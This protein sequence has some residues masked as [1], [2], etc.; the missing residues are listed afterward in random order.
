MCDVVAAHLGSEVC[1]RLFDVLR[2][3][4]AEKDLSLRRPKDK[5]SIIDIFPC[6]RVVFLRGRGLVSVDLPCRI[7]KVNNRAVIHK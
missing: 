5:A 1:D 3:I 6:V 7:L 2:P 4:T